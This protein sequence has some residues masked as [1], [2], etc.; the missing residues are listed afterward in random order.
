MKKILALFLMLALLTLSLAGCGGGGAAASAELKF[1]DSTDFE[2]IK[3][4]DGK[5]V[6]ITGYMATLSPLS[7]DYIYLMNL[8]YQS[9]PFCVP[10]SQQLANTMAVYAAKGVKFEFTDR[11]VKITGNMKI[12]DYT[13]EYGYFYNY[14]IVDA[15]YET[16]DLS[17]VSAEYALYQALAA[18]GVT[19]EINEMFNYLMFLCS[20][21][22]YQGSGTDE[23][24]NAISYYLY[25]GDAQEI[26][27]MEAPYGYA[28]EEAE[29]YFPGL[30]NRVR[31]VGGD[32]LESLVSMI[33][34]A[35][36]LAEY[37]RGEL[38]SG[39]YS[40]NEAADKYELNNAEALISRFQEVYLIFNEWLTAY[41]L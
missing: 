30:I 5:S 36:S 20:W 14:R 6:T 13:D 11:P 4:L 34:N 29:D 26:L 37:A 39:N 40:Y 25:P 10:N 18:D 38:D 19:A 15:K 3:A 9:C 12:E 7:G 17:Q 31:A 16:V 28:A 23:S 8:P 41:E 21:T 1:S 32:S 27:A 33:E 22:D 24:G 35:R 2:T